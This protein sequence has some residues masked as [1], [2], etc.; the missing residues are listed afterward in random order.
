[1]SR[2]LVV[3]GAGEY[4]DPWHPFGATSER[5]GALLRQRHEVTVTTQVAEALAALDADEWDV[6][7]LN[8]GSAE[9]ELPTDAACVDGIARFAAAGGAVLAC[10][11]VATAFPADPRWEHILGGRWV[12]GTTMH[13]PHGD[14]Q[15]RISPAAHPITR[16]LH[17]FVLVDE[18]YSYLRV[19]PD[20]QVL[21]TH[22]HDER[23]HP[24]IWAHHLRASRVVYDGLGHD[25]R[26][27]DSDDHLRLIL[28]AVDWVLGRDE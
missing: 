7:V 23:E 3:S 21:A 11:V 9:R 28:N 19:S 18:R 26:S 5:L 24:V 2:V 16:G 17:D 20:V 12:R 27:Y 25:A 8:F 14:A 13:P 10:H 22:V 4:S 1:V 6:V 15:I